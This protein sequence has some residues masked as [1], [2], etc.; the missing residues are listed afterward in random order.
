MPP[1][2]HTA[3]PSH[4]GERA[5][6]ER[7]VEILGE[8]V[9]LW[10]GLHVPG[11]NEI[12]ILLIH[13]RIGAYVIEVKAKPIDLVLAYDLESCELV[14][15]DSARTP[16]KQAHW[17]MTKLRTFLSDAG[18]ARPPF[19]YATAWF[20]VI[21]AS[22][23]LSRFVPPGIAGSAM[24]MHFNGVLFAD[25]LASV[26]VF[27]SRLR[28]IVERPPIGPSPRR[29]IPGSAQ[30]N[31]VIEATT[32]R[33][34]AIPGSTQPT[35]K[36]LFVAKAGKAQKDSIKRY[37]A[38]ARR[39]P[40]VLHGHPGTGKT[41]AL[42]DIAVAH[43]EAGRQVLFT[44]YNKVLAT[45]LRASFG[46]RD[47]SEA[48]RDRLLIRDVYDI[49]SG[50]NDDLSVY[51]NSFQTICVDE[52]Q[53]MWDS[54][55][56]FVRG[57]AV[58]EAEWFLAD[59]EGQEL[60][61]APNE[62]G[63]PASELLVTARKSGVRQRLIRQFRT[64]PAAALFAQGAFETRLD[65]A[66]VSDWVQQRPV[67]TLSAA[68]DVGI[69][70]AGGLPSISYVQASHE[71]ELVEG[72]ARLIASEL[73]TLRS[74]G[75]P[76]DLMIMVPRLHSTEHERARRALEEVGA[77]FLDQVDTVN[78]RLALPDGHVR[79]VT[80]HSARG[81][82]AER[83]V[84][85]GTHEFA[86]GGSKRIPPE[87]VNRN[88]AYIALTRARHGTRI[89]ILQHGPTSHFQDFVIALHEAYA[90]V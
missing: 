20:P 56:T 62:E 6:A 12:D 58:D 54:L 4:R 50:I 76:K 83:A 48:T 15:Q 57:L 13:E 16:V 44:C 79:L 88:A 41:Q 86:F 73:E 23:M 46:V 63:S 17:A 90:G 66:K 75:K 65:R 3:L 11:G 30:V 10:F 43:A 74:I 27:E 14:G 8:D 85:F 82:A 40:V 67:R 22:E 24:E 49:K 77:P 1:R 7:L 31:D 51:A 21:E 52:A 64:S 34:S 45:A 18:V 71:R 68:L 84:L 2:V 60:Y 38:P 72:Y 80:V 47:I 28:A 5:L 69:D 36:P 39:A 26:G 32:G 61:D 89:V 33:G 9:H 70:D 35:S 81:V 29:P 19:F 87:D 78:R 25:H 53:D 55:M 42:L 37:L 59:G